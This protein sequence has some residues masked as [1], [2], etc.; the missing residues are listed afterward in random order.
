MLNIPKA[1]AMMRNFRV[2]FPVLP[3]RKRPQCAIERLAHQT[4]G[5]ASTCHAASQPS[6]KAGNSYLA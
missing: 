1:A 6:M 5:Q 4:Q 3:C 2:I